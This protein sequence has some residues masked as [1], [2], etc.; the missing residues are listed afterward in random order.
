MIRTETDGAD[1]IGVLV[2]C[3]IESIVIVFLGIMGHLSMFMFIM[4][5]ILLLAINQSCVYT[6]MH[7]LPVFDGSIVYK[8]IIR[9]W[10][11]SI[12][13]LRCTISYL[14]LLVFTT[15]TQL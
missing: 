13:Q 14:D 15:I 9:V 1:C 10:M 8:E 5:P 6:Y 4:M 12:D 11:T 2:I 3:F 7:A